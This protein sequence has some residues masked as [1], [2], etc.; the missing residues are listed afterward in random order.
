[1]EENLANRRDEA[2]KARYIVNEEVCAFMRWMEQLHTQPTIVAF[3]RRGERIIEEE[4]GRTL[5]RLGPVDDDTLDALR[6]M[7]SAMARKFNHDP[8]HFL[9]TEGMEEEA[10]LERIHLIRRIFRLD[11]DSEVPPPRRCRHKG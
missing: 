4:L 7:A 5:R 11:G 1:V 2:A 3:I 9:K 10:S 8:I 6:A